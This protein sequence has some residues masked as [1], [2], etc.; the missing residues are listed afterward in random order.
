MKGKWHGEPFRDYA[1]G[2]WLV[3]FEVYSRPEMYDTTKDKELN[4]EVKE[5]KYK[6]SLEANSYAWVLC[7]ELAK[8]LGTS[9]DD[10]YEGMVQR[11]G[12]LDLDDDGAPIEVAML[13]YIPVSKLGGHWKCIQTYGGYSTYLKL[14]GSSE[15]DTKEMSHFIDGIVSECKELGIETMTPNELE[16]MKQQ[17]KVS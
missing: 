15:M 11:Y 17:W 13:E 2:R 14:K 8:V 4:I 3:T 6:R 7:T 16:R 9:K 5:F 10:I 1:K 12:S